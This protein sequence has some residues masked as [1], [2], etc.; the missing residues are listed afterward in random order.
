MFQNKTDNLAGIQFSLKIYIFQVKKFTCRNIEIKNIVIR[1]GIR[2]ADNREIFKYMVHIRNLFKT[3]YINIL[4][5]LDRLHN[6][7]MI[8]IGKRKLTFQ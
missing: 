3:D 2:A 7:M 4:D 1:N 6:N 5:R 8:V